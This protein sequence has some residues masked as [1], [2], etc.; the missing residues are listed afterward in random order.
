MMPHRLRRATWLLAGT[1]LAALAPLDPAAA[2]PQP[3]TGRPAGIAFD[4]PAQPLGAALNAFAR[5]SGLQVTAE[6]AIVSGATSQAVSGSLTREEALRQLLSGTGL[7]GRVGANR[8]VV[9]NR[10]PPAPAPAG[11][12]GGALLLPEVNVTASTVRSWS[13]VPGYTATLSSSGTKTDTPL[14]ETPQSVSIVTADQIRA[15]D[16]AS[17]TEALAYTPGLT[18]QATTFSRMAD[19]FTIRGFNVADGYSGV[20]RDGLRLNPNVYGLAQEPYGL[21]RIEVVRGAASVLY[22]Q[23][24]PGGLV[25]ATSKRPTEETL[26]ELNL[27]AGSYGRRS[28]AADYGGRL[29]EDGTLSFRLTGLW[30]ESDNWVDYVEDNRQYIAPALTWK[31]DEDTSLTLLASY[32]HTETQFAAPLPYAPVRA[33]TIPQS[34]FNGEPGFDRFDVD[35]YTAGYLF[36]HRFND[37]VTF[38]SGARYFTSS[39]NW[40][41]L[42]FGALTANGTV[43]RGLS[44]RE[45]ASGGFTADNALET[46]FRTG[47]LS[48]TLLAGIDYFSARYNSHRYLSGTTPSINLYNPVYGRR[49]LIN[50]GVDSGSRAEG[51]QVGLY[52]QDQIRLDRLVLTLGGRHDWSGRDTTVFRTNA[53][54]SQDDSAFTGRAGLVYLFDNGLAPYASFSQSFAPNIG[55]D[56]LGAAFTPTRGTQYEAG[57]RFQPPGTDL[58]FSAAAYRLTQTDALVADPVNSNFSIQAGEVRSQGVELEAKGE[59]GPFGFVASYAYTDARTTESTLASQK[60]QRVSLTPYNTVALWGD[61]KLDGIGV[62]GLKLGAGARYVG[63]TNIAGFSRDVPDY[64]LVD[65]SIRY[66]LGTLL[67]KLPGASVSLNA[68][69]ILGEDYFTC[70]G[71]TGC[72]YGAPRTWFAALNYRW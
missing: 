22:G 24:S 54:T 41:Y 9:L 47:P 39:G 33:R 66:D 12:A 46:K 40:D 52:L 32:Q 38:R 34:Y 50:R 17:V 2:Q 49:P 6:A 8:T 51:D 1:T 10:L 61:A 19:D 3:A 57:L 42:T 60:G 20:L 43:T 28:L 31:P 65:A 37:A 27:G 14:L 63:E 68:H 4:I 62:P 48:H 13:P 71:A 5:Q 26:R 45:E 69:N 55:T 36:E 35:A 18:A 23:L 15:T 29:T 44:Q 64:V 11:N 56:R 7:A 70:S 25:N 53:V 30:R 59:Y 16:S 72:R 21:E 67:P 58:I